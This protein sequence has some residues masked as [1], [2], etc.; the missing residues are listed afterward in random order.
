M[1]K[2]KA[3]K[4]KRKLP[5][6]IYQFKWWKDLFRED[7]KDLHEKNAEDRERGLEPCALAHDAS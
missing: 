6:T 1:S 7:P 4:N 2:V 5:K 3:K